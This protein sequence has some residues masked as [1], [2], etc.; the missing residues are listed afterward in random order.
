M[1]A[2]TEESVNCALSATTGNQNCAFPLGFKSDTIMKNLGV[3]WFP[4]CLTTA[5][6]IVSVCCPQLMLLLLLLFGGTLSSILWVKRANDTAVMLTC[7]STRSYAIPQVCVRV[8]GAQDKWV[9]I[10]ASSKEGS[11]GGSFCVRNR[12]TGANVEE[13]E[14]GCTVQGDLIDIRESGNRPQVNNNNADQMEIVFYAQVLFVL[15]PPFLY[16]FS[17]PH[18]ILRILQYWSTH[19][20]HPC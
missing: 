2:L 10:L 18:R 4:T 16:P 5:C 1:T 13:G 19:I 17:H 6:C 11:S 3:R 15:I 14:K 12:F 7:S 8:V 9:E 20:L